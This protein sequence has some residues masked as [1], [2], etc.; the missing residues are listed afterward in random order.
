MFLGEFYLLQL[1]Y[2]N[3]FHHRLHVERRIVSIPI[4]VGYQIEMDLVRFLFI[5]TVFVW[6][7][8]ECIRR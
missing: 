2:F 8:G 1:L 3:R 4:N 6:Y 5:V 7:T